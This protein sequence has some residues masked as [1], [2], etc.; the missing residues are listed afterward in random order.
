MPPLRRV[1]VIRLDHLGDGIF[2]GPA[3]RALRHGLPGAEIV[4]LGGPWAS[5]LYAG[6]GLVD[7]VRSVQVPWFDRPRRNGLGDWGALARW[8]NAWGFDAALDLRGDVRHLVWLALA[9]IPVRLGYPR[10]GGGFLC[11][12]PVVERDVHEVER[13]VDLVRVLVRQAEAG[14]LVPVPWS[15]RDAEAA[16]SSLRAAGTTPDEPYVV[17]HVGAGYASKRWEPE[18]MAA[19]LDR[20]EAQGTGRA[21]LVGTDADRDAVDAVV[22]HA[23]RRPALVVGWTTLPQLAALVARARAFVGHDSGPAHIAVAAGVPSVLV[24]SGVN[25][26]RRWG[27]WG[28]KVHLLHAPVEC[29]PCGLAVCNRQHECMRGFGPDDVAAGVRAL[30]GAGEPA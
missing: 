28:G 8:V 24:Y 9:R 11:T 7:E 21:V 13:N 23:R 29:S 20:I 16:Q 12:H 25:D 19:A 6:T 1:L 10:T 4:L 14:P 17:F 15:A 30:L 18:S 5:A 27:P 2:A 26:P 3:L 22:R